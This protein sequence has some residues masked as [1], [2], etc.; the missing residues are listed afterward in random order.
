MIQFFVN[1]YELTLPDDFSFPL[2][3]ENPEITSN[4]I[5]SFD[6]TLSMLD[7]TNAVAFKHANRLNANRSNQK[8][9]SR[10]ILDGRQIIGSVI[11]FEFTEYSVRFQFVAGNSELK[12][13]SQNSDKIYE[14]NWG[15]ES[16]ITL[17]RAV[18]SI[19]N[20]GWEN[21]FICTPIMA[22]EINLNKFDFD[23]SNV[24]DGKIV[25]QPYLLYYINKLPS[26]L[27]YTLKSNVLE[28]DERAQRMFL[29]NPINSLNYA[30]CLPDMTIAEF[31]KSVEDFFNVTFFASAEDK[32]ISIIKT[33]RRISGKKR[34]ELMPIDG[35]S[36]QIQADEEGFKFGNTKIKYNL[37][38]NNY[39]KFHK[40]SED[41]LAKCEIIE[42]NGT[43]PANTHLDEMVILRDTSTGNDWINSTSQH[44]YDYLGYMVIIGFPNY[45][46]YLVNNF[47]DYGTVDDKILT[48][49]IVPA[50]ICLGK[51]KCIDNDSG[52]S[53]DTYYQMV[54]SSN[55]YY[56]P[57]VETL[58]NQIDTSVKD[59]A[60]LENLEVAIYGGRFKIISGYDVDSGQSN[61]A[62]YTNYPFSTTDFPFDW[63]IN[64]NYYGIID[65][66]PAI[67]SMKLTGVNG[68]V[69]TYR[70]ENILDVNTVWNF[71]IPDS[72]DLSVN[73][74]YCYGGN[75]YIPISFEREIHITEKKLVKGRFFRML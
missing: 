16:E 65:P 66:V 61:R 53:F 21:K 31:V 45:Y 75:D 3:E 42:F 11:D 7:K 18:N 60:R 41:I 27:G 50:E 9:E 51:A 28:E 33:A 67:K 46:S 36:T 52:A 39:F 58:Y 24:K 26:L 34:I 37:T 43:R 30:D 2:I 44:T 55:N 13:L 20:W 38:S 72:V 74:I 47:R 49:K 5:F 14:L 56:L 29:V 59:I 12:Y 62:R 63:N 10:F 17:S 69:N 40:L 71:L 57:T 32:S 48:L 23:F 4:G 64:V 8:L 22:G 70:H 68:V 25:M 15:V 73:N 54:K 19:N 6:M 1:N 35:F